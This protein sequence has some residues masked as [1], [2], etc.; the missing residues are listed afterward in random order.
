LAGAT[1]FFA[2][3]GAAGLLVFGAGFLTVVAGFL[4]VAVLVVALPV[5]VV[6]LAV[7]FAAGFFA[8]VDLDVAMMLSFQK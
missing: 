1:G 8:V 7:G 2:A 5:T 3:T 4:V 6:F